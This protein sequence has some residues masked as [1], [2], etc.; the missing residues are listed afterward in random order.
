MIEIVPFE[1]KYA[2]AFKAL[3]KE[4][5]EQVFEKVGVSDQNLLNDPEERI[6]NTG[7]AIMIALL[8][9]EPVGTCALINKK[10]QGFELA[11][12]AVAPSARGNHIGE[13][14]G[15][16][17]IE[18]VQKLG[19]EKVHLETHSVLVPAINLYKKLG[20]QETCGASSNSLCNLQMELKL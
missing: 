16:A 13:Q 11:K 7:G 10:D 15:K 14:L 3:N 2:G 18:Q 19:G 1:S 12:M 6:I 9:G 5:I 20:F 8:D 17:I 4:W